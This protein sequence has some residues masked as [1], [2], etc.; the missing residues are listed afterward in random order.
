MG[1]RKPAIVLAQPLIPGNTGSIGR[2]CVALDLELIVIHPLGFDLSEQAVRRAGLDYWQHVHLTEYESWES[3]L[4]DRKPPADDLFFFEEFGVQTIYDVPERA[5]PYLV[6]GQETKGLSKDILATPNAG[7]F[8]L[9]MRSAH[10]R[11][12]NLAN[13]VTAVAYQALKHIF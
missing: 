12:L 8:R 4:A 5:A 6:F 7:V 3:F 11:S 2:T 9:P 1:E 10:I 13:S